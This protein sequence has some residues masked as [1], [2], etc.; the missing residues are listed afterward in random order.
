MTT[1]RDYPSNAAVAFCDTILGQRTLAS[2][3]PHLHAICTAA[4]PWLSKKMAM[5]LGGRSLPDT[6]QM[7]HW[8]SLVPSNKASTRMLAG[9]LMRMADAI[10]PEADALM[11]EMFANGTDHPILRTVRKIIDTRC[12]LVRKA[13]DRPGP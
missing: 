11:G 9:E 4:Y 12:A 10:G 5:A 6:I 2:S 8:V 7:E 13:P 1:L 3:E